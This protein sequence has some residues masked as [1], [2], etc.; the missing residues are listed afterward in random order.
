MAAQLIDKFLSF[1]STSFTISIFNVSQCVSK[2]LILLLRI[3]RKLP[4]QC[5]QIIF[6]HISTC[7]NMLIRQVMMAATLTYGNKMDRA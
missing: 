4:T 6:Y 3:P 1:S 7:A 2:E 5:Y